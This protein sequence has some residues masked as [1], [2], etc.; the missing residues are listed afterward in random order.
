MFG[1]FQ[2][3]NASN[4]GPNVNTTFSTMFSDQSAFRIGAW[5]DQLSLRFTPAVPND[6]QGGMRQYDQ[7]RRANTS[8]TLDKAN[9]L[10]TGIDKVIRPAIDEY[11]RTGVLTKPV[12]IAVQ[13]IGKDKR[14]ILAIEFKKDDF[15]EPNVFIVLYQNVTENWTS[16]DNSTYQY[17]FGKNSYITDYDNKTGNSTGE[18][19]VVSEFESFCEFLKNE[20]NLVAFNNHASRYDGEMFK[21]FGNGNYQ[22]Q[23]GAG[24]S[25]FN[26][27]Q[28]SSDLSGYEAPTTSNFGSE[29]FGLPID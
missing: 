25:N 24:Q 10:L 23:N 7:N 18:Y 27:G 2:R 4:G 11:V 22:R 12:S 19:I 15:N 21:R 29:S 26:Q 20:I 14:S 3:N 8:I 16:D 9:I 1:T 13:M 5:N 17:K 28:S 6:G